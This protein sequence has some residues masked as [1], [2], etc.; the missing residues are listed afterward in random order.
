ML[1]TILSI[2]AVFI[3]IQCENPIQA[4][5]NHVI[6]AP[7]TVWQGISGERCMGLAASPKE[8]QLALIIGKTIASDQ[9]DQKFNSNDTIMNRLVILGT[10]SRKIYYQFD[11]GS[12]SLSNLVWSSDGKFLLFLKAQQILLLNI[13]T[14]ILRPLSLP[15][16]NYSRL[17][18]W[19]PSSYDLTVMLN[20]DG[21]IRPGIFNLSKQ[22]TFLIKTSLPDDISDF[23][24]SPGGKYVV[25]CTGDS[26]F[27][28]QYESH[29]KKA[30]AKTRLPVGASLFRWMRGNA[31][32]RKKLGN[33]ALFK[34][35]NQIGIFYLKTNEWQTVGDLQPQ[36]ISDICW[37]S[38]GQ[39]IFY[40]SEE[41][42]NRNKIISEQIL[43]VSP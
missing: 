21:K 5:S 9:Y 27:M 14:G 12:D 33:F 24:W 37:A 1:K 36:Y 38:D 41:N 10:E 20:R 8:K 4:V 2:I 43:Y 32:V 31:D 13:K 22:D 11:F 15:F 16:K 40:I 19:G 6:H 23:N 35:F 7:Q 26:V 39:S 29:S 18:R 42:G 25:Y 28:F 34:N 30:I 17:L 3:F